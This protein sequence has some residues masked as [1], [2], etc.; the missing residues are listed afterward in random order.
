[1]P[2]LSFP[3]PLYPVLAQVT[4]V[5]ARRRLDDTSPGG[6]DNLG[7]VTP[8]VSLLT[9]FEGYITPQGT[10][11]A[12]ALLGTGVG[13]LRGWGAVPVDA[14][15][16]PNATDG[17]KIEAGTLS[18]AINASRAGGLLTGNH[19]AIYTVVVFKA[20]AD[21]SA[22]I[23]ELGRTTAAAATI[24]TSETSRTLNVSIPATEFL[25]GEML[26]IELHTDETSSG[27]AGD[28][29]RIHTNSTS[30]S[31]VLS[32]PNYTIVRPGQFD[33]DGAA[34]P[35]AVGASRGSG[36]FAGT[37]AA[38]SD[39]RQT[40]ILSGVFAAAGAGDAEAIATA[41]FSGAFAAAGAGDAE[42]IA[43]AIFSGVFTA[44]G[45]SDSDWVAASYWSG[46]F[47]G[48]GEAAGD[49]A[50][51]SVAGTVFSADGVAN[52]DWRQTNVFSGVFDAAGEA[53]T[54]V[55]ATA[56][57]SGVF[58]ADGS[59]A[60]EAFGTGIFSGV[61]D[62]DGSSDADYRGSS[63]AGTVFE[64]AGAAATDARLSVVLGTVFEADVSEGGGEAVIRPIYVFDD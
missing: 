46:V 22:V 14:G 25:P 4:D 21:A 2:A 9:P 28:A 33:S 38:A 20:N 63:V 35:A 17:F 15:I 19:T 27:T 36:V 6:T 39:W 29:S 41:I 58:D 32:M 57:F 55:P 43:T 8:S 24:T 60:A 54:Y 47:A 62:A 37:G 34:T 44:D 11:V 23:S 18:F 30:G 49:F 52:S 3:I 16:V 40:D 64:A 7:T 31:R 48:A 51:G 42:A 13:A 45:S 12:G 50:G 5:P 59:S 10:A 26:W 53:I 61:F 56:I 1:V